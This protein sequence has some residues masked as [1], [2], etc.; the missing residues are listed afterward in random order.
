MRSF[1][2]TSLDRQISTAESWSGS[3]G[4]IRN[5][6]LNCSIQ[7]WTQQEQATEQD[8]DV[9]DS[10]DRPVRALPQFAFI[11][12]V[13]RNSEENEAEER[14]ERGAQERKEITHAGDNLGENE[15]NGPD[16]SH[17][18]S[19]NAPSDNRVGV[20]VSRLAHYA[21][22]DELGADIGVDDT[23]NEGWND[24]EG[25]RAFL[26]GCDT[27]TAEC[28]CSRVLAQITET[29]RRWD[30]EQ[31][32][33][34]GCQDS[35]RLGEILWALHLRDESWEENLRNPEESNVQNGVH[36][37]D[38]CR[39]RERKCVCPD[40]AIRWVAPVIAVERSILDTGKYE[41][42]EDSDAHACS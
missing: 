5:N 36:A 12:L 19:P 10:H 17:D 29:N 37:C 6:S 28:W 22:V 27:E 40:Q 24:D 3:S 16:A 15:S 41:E 8:K 30:D 7:P 33:G 39:A 4:I 11:Q 38:P 23:N 14:V 13:I 18:S 42:E 34:N 25:E 21:E 35:Q 26:V 9:S 1:L 32:C 2:Q 20:R 31:E